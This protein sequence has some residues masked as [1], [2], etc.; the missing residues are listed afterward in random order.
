[1]D[2]TGAVSFGYRVE[3]LWDLSFSLLKDTIWRVLESTL[4]NTAPNFAV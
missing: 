2:T 1:M 4:V 3:F